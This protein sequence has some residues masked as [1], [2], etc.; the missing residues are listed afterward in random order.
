[1]E[2]P[3]VPK[4]AELSD[5]KE[6]TSLQ[7][8]SALQ[9]LVAKQHLPFLRLSQ[10]SSC[11][12]HSSRP[13]V[14]GRFSSQFPRVLQFLHT[15]RL[16]FQFKTFQCVF[17][18]LSL[19]QPVPAFGVSPAL[20]LQATQATGQQTVAVPTPQTALPLALLTIPVSAHCP[21]YQL[22]PQ[23]LSQS[24]P[25]PQTVHGLCSTKTLLSSQFLYIVY[26]AVKF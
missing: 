26:C 6:P 24:L 10:D 23:V 5:A 19:L 11:T 4:A 8:A 20:F 18:F 3:S 12:P 7:C 9:K 15:G 22:Q 21:S 2:L 14:L 25:C 16:H 13:C 17:Q 1:M